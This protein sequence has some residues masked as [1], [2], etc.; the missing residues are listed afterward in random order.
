MAVATGYLFR[1]IAKQVEDRGLVVWYDPEKT[2]AQA[3]SELA[4]PLTTIASY[5]DSFFRLRHEIDQ[6]LNADQ[7][8]RLVVYVPMS[9]EE[10]NGALIELEAAGVVMRPGQQPPNRNTKLAVVARNALRPILGDDQVGEVEK[11]VDSGKLSLAD[12]NALAEKGKDI[13]AGIMSLLFGTTNPQ[14]VALAF[15]HD[16]HRDAE[17]EKKAAQEEL[18]NLLQ[19]TFDIQLPASIALASLRDEL[20]RHVLVTDLIT[21]LGPKTPA[22]LLS[23]EVATSPRRGRFLCSARS[24]VAE[25]PRRSPQLRG[26]RQEDRRKSINWRNLR[27]ISRQSSMAAHSSLSSNR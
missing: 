5:S 8:P 6:Q 26:R 9:Q 10:T 27:L 17:I 19:I 20:A 16:K 2:Y 14:E 12:L 13:S 3:A 21:A 22:S 24:V 15:L 25:Q 7:P 23:V 4:L 1:L 18:R 11:Q